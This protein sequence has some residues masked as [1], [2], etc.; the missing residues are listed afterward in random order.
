[1]L[2]RLQQGFTTNS[3]PYARTLIKTDETTKLEKTV[4]ILG[5]VTCCT[6]STLKIYETRKA[7]KRK[8]VTAYKVKTMILNIYRYLSYPI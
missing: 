1:M 7:R 2:L 8:L 6:R 3:L 5:E 4:V